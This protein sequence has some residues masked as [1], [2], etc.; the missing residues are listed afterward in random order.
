MQ[1]AEEAIMLEFLRLNPAQ[2]GGSF[3]SF[4]TGRP[5]EAKEPD[6]VPF[7]TITECLL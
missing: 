5:G 7:D 1:S 2:L 6:L 3:G 4:G